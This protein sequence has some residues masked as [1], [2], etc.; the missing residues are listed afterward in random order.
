MTLTSPNP[1][2]FFLLRSLVCLGPSSLYSHNVGLQDQPG[3]IPGSSYLLPWDV[4]VRLEHDKKGTCSTEVS[5]YRKNHV[6]RVRKNKAGEWSLP[7]L[8]AF[9]KNVLNKFKNISDQSEFVVKIFVGVE[10]ECPRGHRFMTA[11]PDKIMKT[12]NCGQVKDTAQKVTSADMPLYFPCVCR[13]VN[14]VVC[15]ED[16]LNAIS[17]VF[18][19]F[20]QVQQ[21]S[22][23]STDEDS[24]GHAE[25]PRQSHIES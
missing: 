2:F 9:S 5:E 12:T 18:Y 23:S 3:L 11:G 19:Y 17:K 22:D 21:T 1:F 15:F 13:W 10:Y 4:T 24:H 20:S 16:P 14:L 8:H 7:N 25:S 6:M